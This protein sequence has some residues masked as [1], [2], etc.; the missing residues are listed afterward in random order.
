MRPL[1]LKQDLNFDKLSMAGY[2][3]N[4]FLQD[5][6]T[7]V[8]LDNDDLWLSKTCYNNTENITRR[9]TSY[10]VGTLSLCTKIESNKSSSKAKYMYIC[11][12]T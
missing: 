11:S 10:S 3:V 8:T 1:D 12:C 2:M 5:N 9:N 4:L 6:D 7:V